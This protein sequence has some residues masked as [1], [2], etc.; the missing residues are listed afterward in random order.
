LCRLTSTF[1][2]AIGVKEP[3]SFAED[4]RHT[5]ISGKSL[6]KRIDNEYG[7]TIVNIYRVN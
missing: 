7:E 5:N 6:V 1:S 3:L 4:W 2:Y